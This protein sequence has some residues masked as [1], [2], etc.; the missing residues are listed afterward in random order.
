[1]KLPHAVINLQQNEVGDIAGQG[2]R[3]AGTKRVY[4]QPWDE[5]RVTSRQWTGIRAWI[6]DKNHWGFAERSGQAHCNPLILQTLWVFF[7]EAK[8][9]R[10]EKTAI[11]QNIAIIKRISFGIVFFFYKVAFWPQNAGLT[12][13]PGF[14]YY[15]A[16]RFLKS[17]QVSPFWVMQGHKSS[18]Q[19]ALP[20]W[21][22]WA[23]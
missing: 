1:M 13:C 20:P 4:Q 14:D 5:I 23:V 8:R 2:V 19:K 17:Y 21:A 10:K 15:S 18:R 12:E 3:A 7:G 11:N 9:Y 16:T 6:N 22:W